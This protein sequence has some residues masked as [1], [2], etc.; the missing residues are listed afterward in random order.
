MAILYGYFLTLRII[1]D[2]GIT[3][4]IVYLSIAYIGLMDVV[5]PID[6]RDRL[7]VPRRKWPRH[8]YREWSKLKP[9]DVR[10]MKRVVLEYCDRNRKS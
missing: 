5:A 6:L 2:N 7:N 10:L 8:L 1:R 4:S 9:R 3:I